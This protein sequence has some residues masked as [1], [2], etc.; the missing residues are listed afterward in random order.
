[1]G[2][3]DKIKLWIEKERISMIQGNCSHEEW[4]MDVQIRTIRC[5]KCGKSAWVREIKDLYRN[6]N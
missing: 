1:M 4:D 6:K 5:K 2:R 3:M